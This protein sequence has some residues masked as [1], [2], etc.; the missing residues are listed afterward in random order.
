MFY[1]PIC[2]HENASFEC[3]QSG[4]RLLIKNTDEVLVE[5]SVILYVYL[6]V[7]FFQFF[8]LLRA[9]KQYLNVQKI[10]FFVQ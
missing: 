4:L 5:V 8:N 2:S 1:I 3:F 9:D 7:V 10:E 6:S